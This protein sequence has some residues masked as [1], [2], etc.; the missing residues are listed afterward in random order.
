MTDTVSDYDRSTT[1][2]IVRRPATRE[3]TTAD[4]RFAS[5]PERCPP[6][7]PRPESGGLSDPNLREKVLPK[8]TP[9]DAPL[10]ASRV[11]DEPPVSLDDVLGSDA[12]VMRSPRQ[13]GESRIVPRRMLKHV[14]SK[15]VWVGIGA[16][17]LAG[18]ALLVIDLLLHRA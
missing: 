14:P 2:A 1:P 7:V 4:Q 18:L 5:V 11:D 16:V 17:M 9:L 6:G 10:P 12:L 8:A 3:P 13:S 15:W